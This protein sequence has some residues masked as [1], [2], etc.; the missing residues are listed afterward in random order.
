MVITKYFLLPLLTGMIV[1][2]FLPNHAES[3]ADK[4]LTVAG[5]VLTVS[6]LVLLVMHWQLLV[7]AGWPALLALSALTL[8]SLIIGH[9]MGGEEPGERTALAVA[10]ATRHLGLA[11][12]VAAAVP[13]PKTAVFIAAYLVASAIVVIPYLKW[14]SKVNAVS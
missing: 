12:L 3:F 10:C 7:R 5:L 9:L 11:I 4:I 2:K 14:Q 8:I 1:R 6:A 13:G